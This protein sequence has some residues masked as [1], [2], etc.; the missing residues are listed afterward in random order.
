M[1]VLRQS[2]CVDR[3][4]A[5][6]WDVTLGTRAA[7]RGEKPPL[8]YCHG[9]GDLARTL[10]AKT[11]QR[12]LIR[13]L[14]KDFLVC[15]ADLGA[16]TWGNDTVISRIAAV[17]AYLAAL[18]ADGPAVLV[19]V[20]M[21]NLSAMAYARANPTQVAAIAGVIPA[22]DLNDIHA[23]NRGGAAA[24]VNT[25]Y[26]GAYVQATHGPTHNPVTYA[27]TLPASLPIAIWTATDDPLC[28]PATTT[29]FMTARPG[30]GS[31]SVGALGHSEASVAA[32]ATGVVAF[33]EE[34]T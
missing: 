11:A 31:N 22:L 14:A 12:A 5:G 6:E 25:A 15:I 7:W 26:G 34:Y 33:I 18:G 24:G 20:S 23:N 3:I 27:A 28:V 10:Y 2:V 13:S 29:T 21:G 4:T 19:G 16:E 1:T 32:A 8:I 9:S 30:T 17:K